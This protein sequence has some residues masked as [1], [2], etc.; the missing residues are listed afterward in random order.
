MKNKI[1]E[2]EGFTVIQFV[3]SGRLPGLWKSMILK[4][5]INS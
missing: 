2:E 5:K 3:G 1:L 4:A